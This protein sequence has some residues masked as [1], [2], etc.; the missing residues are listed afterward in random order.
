M[1][2]WELTKVVAGVGSAVVVALAG[3][4]FSGQVI[5]PPFPDRTI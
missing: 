1:D 5:E 3:Y 4:W 2:G